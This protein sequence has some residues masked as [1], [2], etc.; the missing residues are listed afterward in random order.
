MKNLDVRRRI[1]SK[2][3]VAVTAATLAGAAAGAVLGVLAY[4]NGWLG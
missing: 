3:S 4:Y 1:F 2:S